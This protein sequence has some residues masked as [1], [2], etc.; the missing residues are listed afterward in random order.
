M[1]QRLGPYVTDEDLCE[2]GKF[3]LEGFANFHGHGGSTGTQKVNPAPN[4]EYAVG[5]LLST[6]STASWEI[7][8]SPR[9]YEKSRVRTIVFRS[10][11]T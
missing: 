2:C 7:S 1:V 4:M 3:F 8:H 11:E 5:P 10:W 9:K 6:G